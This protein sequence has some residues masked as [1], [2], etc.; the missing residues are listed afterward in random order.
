M[1]QTC[2]LFTPATHHFEIPIQ[3][4]LAISSAFSCITGPV[5]DKAFTCTTAS[6]II[7]MVT[8]LLSYNATECCFPRKPDIAVI[9]PIRNICFTYNRYIPH[10]FLYAFYE[11]NVY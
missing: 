8:I 7:L 9:P 3:K 6:S 11:S 5:I 1:T 10:T 4:D 2:E